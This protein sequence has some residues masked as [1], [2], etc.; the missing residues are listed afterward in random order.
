MSHIYVIAGI[1]K[2][3]IR[4]YLSKVNKIVLGYQTRDTIFNSKVGI[5]QLLLLSDV[6]YLYDVDN[7]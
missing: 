3:K 5:R 1:K 2:N 7:K 4:L 6:Y